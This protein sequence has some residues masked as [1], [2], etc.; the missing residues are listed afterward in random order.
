MRLLS[1]I[2]AAV[3]A[4][5]LCQSGPVIAQTTAKDVSKATAD[6]WDTVKGYSVE[7]KTA[8]VAYRK[9]LI[10][11]SDPE[12]KKLEAKASKATGDTKAEYDKEIKDLKAKRAA[13]SKKID[14]MGKASASAWDTAKNG[15]ADAYK[16]L[17]D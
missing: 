12:I 17:R 11:D 14:E 15:F 2:F 5:V 4:T 16:D 10:R 1:L 9:K 6:A 13:T 8:A 3:F 7:K